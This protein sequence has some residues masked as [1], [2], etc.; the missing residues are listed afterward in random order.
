MKKKLQR[1]DILVSVIVFAA[2]AVTM[3]VGLVNWGSALLQSVR[4]VG[5]REQALQ[6][7]EAGIDYYRWHL[8]HAP[9]DFFDGTGS[10]STSPYTHQFFDKDG[11]L[12]GSYALTITAPRIGSTIVTI[13]SQGTL[14]S[15][16]ISRKLKVTMAIPSFAQYATI[17]ND[18]MYFGLG[19]VTFGPIQ[20]NG[21]IHFDG[22][23]H[24]PVSSALSTYTDPDYNAT[25]WAVYTTSGSADP[26]PPTVL[27]TRSDIFTVG[28]QMSVPAIDFSS[29][30]ANL[31]T[32]KTTAQSGG[33]YLTQSQYSGNRAQGYHIVLKTNDT[34]D[35][36]VVRS[37]QSPNSTCTNNSSGQNQWG[38]WSINT[39]LPAPQTS[40]SNQS[41]VANYALPSN[42]VIYVEDH[43]W[44]DGQINGAHVTVVAGVLPD[45]GVTHEPNITINGNLLYTNFDG[46]DTIGLIAQGNINVGY[47]S[48]DTQTIDAAL[49]AQNGRVGRFYYDSTCGASYHRSTLSLYGMI[50]TYIRYGFAWTGGVFNCGGALTLSSGYCTRNITYDAN[51][52]YG[53]PPSFPLT[54]SYYSTLSWQEI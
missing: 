49:V 18:N 16:T 29:L 8:A 37:I 38:L 15:S 24:G 20:S 46:S 52:L 26:N 42:G 48:L 19:T 54:S 44:I 45:P 6:V 14:A 22:V 13:V 3:T 47:D 34:F 5:Q 23:A 43:V 33:V 30:T 27:P 12:L 28:R 21:G 17:A 4:I 50:G 7:A 53:P 9:N 11:N 39:P 32:L 31:A 2:I 1:G 35:L 41:F 51:L 40:N 36:Y 25:R 10:T